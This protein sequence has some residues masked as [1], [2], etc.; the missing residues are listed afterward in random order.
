M[1]EKKKKEAEICLNSY[2][3]LPFIYEVL[4]YLK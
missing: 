2:N 1:K 4:P 3:C